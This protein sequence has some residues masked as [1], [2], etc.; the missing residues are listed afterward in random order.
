M[1][2]RAYDEAAARK[3]ARLWFVR[4]VDVQLLG[5]SAASVYRAG[6]AVLRLG[7]P[8]LRSSA[9]VT[10]EMRFVAEVK[11][12]GEVRVAGPLRSRAGS[13]VE[14][15]DG[16][17]VSVIEWA[18]GIK[19][20]EPPA[21]CD[22]VLAAWGR[23]LAGVHEAARVVAP[24]V[25]AARW[26]WEDEVWLVEGPRLCKDDAVLREWQAV[27]AHLAARPRSHTGLI[28]GDLG[29]QN[30]HADGARL[31]LF[32]FGNCCRHFFAMDL[33]I[34][35]TL[36]RGRE[37]DQRRRA[38]RVLLDAYQAAAPLP[39]DELAEVGWL[40]RLRAVYVYFSRLWAYGKVEERIRA[41]VGLDD[42]V[43]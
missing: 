40:A 17:V 34:A 13:Y 31:T 37:P 14:E 21:V 16:A 43:V 6:P 25:A 12:R 29:P 15:V 26:W 3:A 28:H 41:R 30:F 22:D 27:R 8:R 9:Q 1:R 32:D 5:H 36:L 7:D 18:P 2:L 38:W 23:S 11:R 19:V 39:E 33:A 4:E 20:S 35:W 42:W 10:A 24:E